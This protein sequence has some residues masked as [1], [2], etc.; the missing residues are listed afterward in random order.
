MEREQMPFC[1]VGTSATHNADSRVLEES[2]KGILEAGFTHTELSGPGYGL[3]L[4]GKVNP[5]ALRRLKTVTDRFRDRLRYTIHGPIA[6]HLMDQRDFA[7][8]AQLLRAGL[9]AAREIGVEVFVYE[10][11]WVQEW[12]AGGFLG[13]EEFKKREREL[14]REMGEEVAA[15]GGRI[16]IETMAGLE[17]QR[18]YADLPSEL[19]EYIAS[20][21]HPNIGICIDTGHSFLGSNRMGW[22]FLDGVRTLAPYVFTFHLQDNFGRSVSPHLGLNHRSPESW[23]LGLGD[24]HLPLGWGEIPFGPML[25]GIEFPRNPVLMMEVSW[26][27]FRDFMPEQRIQLAGWGGLS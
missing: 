23:A 9:E 19:A 27:S 24:L 17:F 22:D 13:M 15:W 12:P 25:T 3:W 8:R 20:I 11:G 14:L 18:C 1:G 4:A 5:P 6:F 10:S 16:A 21:D 26:D 7:L 2:L